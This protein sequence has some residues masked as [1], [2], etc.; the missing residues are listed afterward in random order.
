MIECANVRLP[1]F[2]VYGVRCFDLSSFDVFEFPKFECTRLKRFNFWV[3]EPNNVRFPDDDVLY[4][5]ILA[6]R[7]YEVR[8]F[9]LTSSRRPYYELRFPSF[10]KL[11]FK[12]ST[13]LFP[14]SEVIIQRVRFSKFI[15]VH[16]LHVSTSIV[17]C[18]VCLIF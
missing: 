18:I 4:F 5:L 16:L 2:R 1:E 15:C 17:F 11:R 6:F 7:N 13:L 3:S 14:S 12:V 9:E 8:C 10:R